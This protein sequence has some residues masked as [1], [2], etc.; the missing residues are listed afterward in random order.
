MRYFLLLL[1]A[2]PFFS[3]CGNSKKNMKEENT[4][5]FTY[6]QTACFGQCPVFKLE[7]Y[8]NGQLHYEG[9]AFVNKEEKYTKTISPDK[10]QEIVDLFLESKFFEF[11]DEYTSTVQDFPTYYFSFTHD[12]KTKKVKDH[13]GSP[14]A[15]KALRKP[16]TNLVNDEEGWKKA[17]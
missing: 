7:I 11:E 9:K 13:Y 15:L 4:L 12:G 14:E 1:I 16:F 6:E 2:L 3:G 10:V 8:S 5:V 17:E